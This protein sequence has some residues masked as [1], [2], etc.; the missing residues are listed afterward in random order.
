[1]ALAENEQEDAW[2]PWQLGDEAQILG[3]DEQVLRVVDEDSVDEGFDEQTESLHSF[4]VP[5]YRSSQ[6][7]CL[8]T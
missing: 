2:R 7:Q 3:T 4:P 6:W 5:W 8:T 1:M